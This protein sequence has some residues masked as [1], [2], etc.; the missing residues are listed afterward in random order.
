MQLDFE[1]KFPFHYFGK[2]LLMSLWTEVT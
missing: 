2:S 1:S